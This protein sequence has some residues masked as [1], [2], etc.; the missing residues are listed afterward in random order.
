MPAR[1]RRG[2]RLE[3]DFRLARA[4]DAVEQGHREAVF[5]IGEQ[6]ARRLLPDLHAMPLDLSKQ[7][8][9]LTAEQQEA[10]RDLLADTK[11]G[12]TV[13]LLDGVTGSGKTEVY[14]EA[15]ARRS[16]AGSRR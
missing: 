4:G 5:G 13:T 8:T 7:S 14:F 6:I 15:V 10:A 9:Q 12:F 2:D 16:R 3:I 11:D 1:E